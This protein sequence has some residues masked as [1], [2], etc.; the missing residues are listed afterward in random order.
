[1]QVG[2]IMGWMRE[3]DIS[4]SMTLNGERLHLEC[5][6]C[7]D[8]LRESATE[9]LVGIP[10][11]NESEVIGTVVKDVLEYADEVVVVDDGSGDET[12]SIANSNGA[13]VIQHDYSKGYGAAIKTLFQY[14]DESC[15]D[16]LVILDADGQHE[17]SHIPKLVSARDEMNCDI[18][19]G[20][21]S[22]NG[23]RSEMYFTRRFGFFVI[24]SLTNLTLGTL[25]T[26]SWITDSQSGFRVYGQ[27]IVRSL[28]QD[29]TLSDHMGASIDILHHAR[30]KGFRIC[31]IGTNIY[32]PPE[33]SNSHTPLTHG[34]ILF[35]TLI[36]TVER[37]HPILAFGA[38]GF[39]FLLFSIG[40]GNWTVY[41][42]LNSGTFPYGIAIVTSFFGLTGLF[43][44]MT[45]VILHSLKL[46]F[47]AAN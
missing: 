12:S 7:S 36:R 38:P 30:R 9:L 2:V 47:D 22:I 43:G 41:N 40:F 19:I 34:M 20:S 25:S 15:V 14:A 6:Q 42:Y 23:H 27:A 1:M 37:E 21:R 44:I 8:P 46:H 28:A 5:D 29:Q 33:S 17:P 18:V 26:N 10:A 13:T 31:E 16:D 3:I 39:V 24:N 32:Y 35:N 11:Y 45:G 4:S